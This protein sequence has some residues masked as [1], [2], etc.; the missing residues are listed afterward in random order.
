[1]KHYD[2]IIAGA[3]V[4]GAVVA[5]R[6]AAAGASVL[7]VE[8]RNHIGGNCFDAPDAQGILIHPY[9]P[10]IF[11]T[12]K[13]PVVEYLSRF[14]AWRPYE[15]RVVGMLPGGGAQ[16][17]VPLPF[18]LTSLQMCFP[19]SEAAHMEKALVEGF[20]MG[21]SV[22]I[23]KL[24]ESTDPALNA[25]AEF[26]YE[27]VFLGY[28]RKQWGL[29]PT[30][31][32]PEIT[33]RV[34]VRV[35]HDDRYF[36]DTFQCMP[37]DGF[38]PMFATMLQHE[39]ITVATSTAFEDVQDTHS[40][41]ACV[42]TGP[43]D[44]Y[45]DYQLGALPYRSLDFTFEHYHQPRHLPAGVVNYPDFATPFTRI[46]EYRI[47]TGQEAQ[48]TTVSLEYP[49]AHRPGETIPYYP[50]ITDDNTALHHRYIALAREEAPHIRFAGRLGNYRYHNID[51]AVL[52]ALHLA[53]DV[54]ALAQGAC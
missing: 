39:N 14:T 29:S 3:G 25:L 12:S 2:I 8:Q 20:G 7:V 40:C 22:P 5:E 13:E 43:I 31:I 16:R 21:A 32:S 30:E 6:C 27:Q 48:G 36:T 28:T 9:G 33:G 24:R 26:I 19:A 44:A 10:H 4:T 54:L 49:L 17:L 37:R 53:D 11:H 35:S 41:K 42:H 45:F 51:D 15:H 50:I 34:P 23:L 46:S 38:T 18:N 1:M 52:A 47:L